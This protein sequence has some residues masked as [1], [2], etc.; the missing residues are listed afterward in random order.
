MAEA[1][2]PTPR[3]D[4]LPRWYRDAIH[5][6]KPAGDDPARHPTVIR[7]YGVHGDFRVGAGRRG[8]SR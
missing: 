5:E 7:P 3:T 1:P 4:D 8:R 2:G 6:A